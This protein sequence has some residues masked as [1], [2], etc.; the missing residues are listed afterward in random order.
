[1]SKRGL[2]LY[3][4][5]DGIFEGRYSDDHGENDKIKYRSIYGKTY[6]EARKDFCKLLFFA[7]F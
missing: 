6:T 7:A 3:R 2:N 5:K 1:M 4:R